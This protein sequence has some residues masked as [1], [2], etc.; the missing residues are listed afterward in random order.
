MINQEPCLACLLVAHSRCKY[1]LRLFCQQCHRNR[2][3][4]TERQCS[5]TPD[6]RVFMADGHFL[7]SIPRF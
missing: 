4:V 6:A 5:G 1:C 7:E 2:Y 3:E